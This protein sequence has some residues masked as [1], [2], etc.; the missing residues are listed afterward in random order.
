M[1][2]A[3]A[4]P[5]R[6]QATHTPWPEDIPKVSEPSNQPRPASGAQGVSKALDVPSWV[7]FQAKLIHSCFDICGRHGSPSSVSHLP[8]TFEQLQLLCS[9][10]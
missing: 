6:K 3:E 2:Q 1:E 5:R 7:H 9:H 4:E 8:N 10:L